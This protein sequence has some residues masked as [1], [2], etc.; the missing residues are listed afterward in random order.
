MSEPLPFSRH[1][2]PSHIW[3]YSDELD[4]NLCPCGALATYPKERPLNLLAD[5]PCDRVTIQAQISAELAYFSGGR[6]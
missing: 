4:L 1:S 3:T 5:Y 2:D 6:H